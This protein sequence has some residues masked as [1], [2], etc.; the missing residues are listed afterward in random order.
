VLV[1]VKNKHEKSLLVRLP[2]VEKTSRLGS[3]DP[4]ASG[5]KCGQ[6]GGKNSK[7]KS[8][9][10][11]WLSL[12]T[13]VEQGHRGSQVK[14]G[15]WRRLHRARGVCCGSIENHWVAWLRHKAKAEDSVWLS[16]Q[17]WSDRL[18]KPVWPVWGLRDMG[19]HGSPLTRVPKVTI[20]WT[21]PARSSATYKWAPRPYQQPRRPW[22]TSGDL[23]QTL[24][25]L[26]GL[27][28]K[29]LPQITTWRH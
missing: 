18:V 2:G 3:R 14:S 13:K 7:T 6:H 4:V 19:T 10:V 22:K 1:Q 11:S 26:P 12:K 27:W 28:R 15:N 9:T 29:L 23:I 20:K 17:N 25:D 16:S 5:V 8:W 21:Q 24:E